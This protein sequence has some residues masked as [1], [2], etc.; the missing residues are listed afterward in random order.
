M[1]S[2]SALL[3]AGTP[4]EMHLFRHGAHGSGLGKGD[5]S[6]DLWRDLLEAWLRAQG[7]LTSEHATAEG[8]SKIE[9]GHALGRDTLRTFCG[10]K[11]GSA[12]GRG[13]GRLSDRLNL[14]K[15]LAIGRLGL[16]SSRACHFAL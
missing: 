10:A 9:R 16:L 8:E 15:L 1:E 2:Y 14:C 13:V 11:P 7:W 4:A 6:L 3:R 12:F 5:A